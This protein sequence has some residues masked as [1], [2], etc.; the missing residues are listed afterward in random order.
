M[1]L[2][3]IP[4]LNRFF[5][6]IWYMS[7]TLLVLLG[8]TP[9]VAVVER[10]GV[11]KAIKRGVCFVLVR[12]REV[13]LFLL[14]LTALRWLSQVPYNI[15]RSIPRETLSPWTISSDLVLWEIGATPWKLLRELGLGFL[16][17]W[18]AITA[19]AWYL[20]GRSTCQP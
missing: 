18:F 19:M 8:I 16:S 9:T 7:L 10:T 6:S 15:V 2:S 12:W 20:R 14:F 17:L 11:R 5:L 3:T 4:P 1:A 13:L